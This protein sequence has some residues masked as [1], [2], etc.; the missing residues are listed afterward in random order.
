MITQT[1]KADKA[2]ND[3]DQLVERMESAAK[4]ANPTPKDAD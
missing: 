1:D 3:I 4:A 2:M